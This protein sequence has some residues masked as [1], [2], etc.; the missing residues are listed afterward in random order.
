MT[1]EGVFLITGTSGLLGRRL[2]RVLTREYPQMRVVAAI[3]TEDSIE[4][5]NNIKYTSGDLTLTESWAKMPDNVTHVFHLAAAIPRGGGADDTSVALN[6]I[7]PVVHL[8]A[9]THHWRHLRQVVYSSSISVYADT[10]DIIN[11]DS[12]LGPADAY[13]ASKLAGEN[14]LT[15][16]RKKGVRT[17]FL[18]YSSL[19]GNGQYPGTVLPVMI[20]CAMKNRE[21]LVYGSGER[22]QDFLHC[23]DAAIANVLAARRQADGVFNIGSGTPVTMSELAQAVNRVFASGEAKITYLPDKDDGDMGRKINISRARHELTF[24]PKYQI[25][26]GLEQLKTG[27]GLN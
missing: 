3:R 9:Q 12:Q 15:P 6:N 27:M 22:T 17:A 20:D 7:L 14:L 26:E 1:D 23:E 19:Y 2:L 10:P 16:L 4:A 21:I 8:A 25:E 11:E 18:R 13:A 5:D 24:S